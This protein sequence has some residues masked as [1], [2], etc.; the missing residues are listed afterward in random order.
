[1]VRHYHRVLVHELLRHGSVVGTRVIFMDYEVSTIPPRRSLHYS[2]NGVS[3]LLT[4]WPALNFHSLSTAGTNADPVGSHM[5]VS[6]TFWSDL[7]HVPDA[8]LFHQEA[9]I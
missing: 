6:I 5:I 1:V 4:Q 7:W 2:D 8:E 3:I 9:A